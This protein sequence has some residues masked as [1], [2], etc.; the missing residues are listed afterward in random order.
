M[1]RVLL[2]RKMAGD[3]AIAKSARKRSV[4]DVQVVGVANLKPS[5]IGKAM[6]VKE[7]RKWTVT[8][9][10]GSRQ[11][12]ISFILLDQQVMLLDTIY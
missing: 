6:R 10:R 1:V 5:D 12:T 2:Q 8:S 4:E 11:A 3:A 9:P 7:Y